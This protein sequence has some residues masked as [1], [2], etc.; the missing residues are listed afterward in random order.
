MALET[1]RDTIRQ[2]AQHIGNA[3]TGPPEPHSVAA[4]A[5]SPSLGTEAGINRQ[6]RIQCILEHAIREALQDR[7]NMHFP[8]RS[9]YESIGLILAADPS[10]NCAKEF[11]AAVE[12]TVRALTADKDT[13]EAF[14]VG[15]AIKSVIDP[16]P[17]H[18]APLLSVFRA[19]DAVLSCLQLLRSVA[20][21]KT[22]GDTLVQLVES[23]IRI[24]T[25]EIRQEMVQTAVSFGGGMA[26]DLMHQL[27]SCAIRYMHGRAHFSSHEDITNL[28]ELIKEKA[29]LPV[30]DYAYDAFRFRLGYE[31]HNP[32]IPSSIEAI[33]AGALHPMSGVET[34][35]VLEPVPRAVADEVLSLPRI[36]SF[37]QEWSP[38]RIAPDA[39]ALTD[40]SG[41]IVSIA[42]VP[43]D[44][45]LST[46]SAIDVRDIP[47]LESECRDPSAPRPLITQAESML[48]TID[49]RIVKPLVGEIEAQRKGLLGKVLE[50][51]MPARLSIW[52]KLLP[53]IPT[54]DL[55]V[56]VDNCFDFN[57]TDVF[58]IFRSSMPDPLRQSPLIEW[59]HSPPLFEVLR[60][61]YTREEA[62]LIPTTTVEIDSLTSRPELC[63]FSID[64]ADLVIPTLQQLTR[65]LL[66]LRL[67]KDLGI[68]LNDVPIR[69]QLHLMRYCATLHSAA[70][71]SL[72]SL[73]REDPVYGHRF[74]SS[75]ISYAQDRESSQALIAIASN[76]D[77]LSRRRFIT[78]YNM[79][80]DKALE[81]ERALER[82]PSA[83][84]DPGLIRNVHRELVGRTNARVKA[85]ALEI[86]TEN[87]PDVE[88]IVEEFENLNAEVLLIGALF[89]V[90]SRQDGVTLDQVKGAHLKTIRATEL[91][92][93]D[94]QKMMEIGSRNNTQYPPDIEKLA[95]S[96][97][98]ESFTDSSS[99][100]CILTVT[101]EAR[102]SIV[103]FARV[104]EIDDE[105]KT[106]YIGSINSLPE[107]K[108]LSFGTAFM[109]ILFGEMYRDRWIEMKSWDKTRAV[110][111][112]VD[113]YGFEAFKATEFG[114]SL[115]IGLRRR[116][117]TT[118][119]SAP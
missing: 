105:R 112:Y 78:T 13:R 60:Q 14:R 50:Y 116:P 9:A 100:F 18:T 57:N 70:W 5:A 25:P 58:K 3:A 39:I 40:R 1:D 28:I 79:L 98:A 31:K 104:Q 20:L 4:T 11:T 32:S 103:S 80:A 53:N 66:R 84:A 48:Q 86:E 22:C 12:V 76:L 102:E 24:S 83:S 81:L 17:F 109:D 47:V 56:L 21:R 36:F 65:P 30:V 106:L 107:V 49:T 23:A 62:R 87:Q 68:T 8:T 101:D 51:C 55:K 42:L 6:E 96:D 89:N 113:R 110:A 115:L 34:A 52:Q 94:R 2:P 77:T 46:R 95:N 117:I 118:T 37:S 75:F 69:S 26:L 92:I 67:E 97:L 29:Q 74:L 54:R 73:V 41:M 88:A 44:L 108:G 119:S 45:P 19:P 61:I 93:K 38:H 63:P 82:F 114:E 64:E 10:S 85:I 71:N 35:R 27:Q 91:T 16:D 99:S 59:K 43:R 15:E 90:L 33:S 111:Q 7:Q 72:C